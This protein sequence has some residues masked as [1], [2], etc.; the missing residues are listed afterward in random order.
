[1]T[2]FAEIDRMTFAEYKLRVTAY[3]LKQLDK[4][5][6][7]ALSA[8]QHN[9]VTAKRKE[10]KKLIPVYKR[11]KDFFDYE[12]AEAKILKSKTEPDK[13]QKIANRLMEFYS[14]K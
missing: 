13:K 7:I 9:E 10:G 6:M 11:F 8:W 2:D 3:E 1:M 4:E 5:Y 14:K 12:E